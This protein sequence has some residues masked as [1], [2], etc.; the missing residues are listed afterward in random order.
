MWRGMVIGTMM[1]MT[2]AVFCDS[3]VL[4]ICSI[5]C[6]ILSYLCWKDTGGEG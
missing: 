1:C 5:T 3:V 4:S 6:A 2:G